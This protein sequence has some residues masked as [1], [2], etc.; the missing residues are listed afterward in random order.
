VVTKQPR[1]KSAFSLG[2]PRESKSRPEVILI[3]L[4]NPPPKRRVSIRD[5]NAVQQIAASFYE[6]RT[7]CIRKWRSIGRGVILRKECRQHVVRIDR[8]AKQLITHSVVDLQVRFYLPG[9]LRVELSPPKPQM[10][11]HVELR[12]AIGARAPK[13]EIRQRPP[14]S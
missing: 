11:G 13:Q 2:A 6:L 4:L 1:K 12:L 14:A 7:R 3:Q 8:R 5:H 9:V 10:I